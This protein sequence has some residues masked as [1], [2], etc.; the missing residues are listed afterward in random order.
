MTLVGRPLCPISLILVS[1]NLL[2]FSLLK[3]MSCFAKNAMNCFFKSSVS[4]EKAIS[5]MVFFCFL[6]LKLVRFVFWHFLGVS[7]S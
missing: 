6:L 5:F 2:S 1:R 3:S 7:V 4:F